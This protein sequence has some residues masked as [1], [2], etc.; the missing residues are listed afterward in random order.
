MY[1]IVKKKKLLMVHARC[2]YVG[3]VC[4][5]LIYASMITAV[6][7]KVTRAISTHILLEKASRMSILNFNRGE[8]M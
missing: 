5:T 4:T 2:M 7:G 6:A 3:G 8:E 1:L